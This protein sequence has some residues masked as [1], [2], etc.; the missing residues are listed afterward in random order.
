MAE[1][2][3][4]VSFRSG[5]PSARLKELDWSDA[6]ARCQHR[7][8]MVW[9]KEPI[10]ECQDCGAVVDPYAWIRARCADWSSLI[11][12]LKRK[13]AEM[14]GEIAELRKALRALRGEFKDEAER[15]A[16]ERALHV[17]PKKR[18]Y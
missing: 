11:A 5:A 4:V 2:D 18:G 1:D 16:A 12:P 6:R 14:E 17:W 13:K 7:S 15:R 8:V 3:N 10:L 9:A